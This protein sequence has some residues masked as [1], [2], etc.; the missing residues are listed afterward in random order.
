MIEV[1]RLPNES[2]E[3]LIYR[4]CSMKDSFGTWSEVRDILNKLLDKDYSE[5]KYRKW[6]KVYQAGLE[7]GLKKGQ[8]DS[9]YSDLDDKLNALKKERKKIQALNVERNKYDREETRRELFYEQIAENITSLPLVSFG[10]ISDEENVDHHDFEKEYVLCLADIH[11]GAKFKESYDEYSME[12]VQER[13]LCLL[14]EMSYF[15][16]DK[17]INHLHVLE[18][19]DTVQGLIHLS[20][21]KIIDSSMVRTIVEIS[22]LIAEFLN[23]LSSITKITY[24]HCGRANHTQIR[25]FNAKANEL[26]EEDVE[27]IIGHYIQDLL[28]NNDRVE[29]ILPDVNQSYIKLN[30]RANDIY[31]MHGHQLRNTDKAIDDVSNYL[32]ETVDYLIVGHEH[33]SKEI[34]TNAYSTFDK[35][36]LVCPSFVGSDP[37]SHSI[38]KRTHGAV[39]VFGF[40]EVYGHNETYKFI[41]D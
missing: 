41:L 32:A 28:R 16:K 3:S 14:D 13:F 15:I 34:T 33:C 25:A 22:R 20:D 38:L 17:G 5:S 4:V 9:D 1:K 23:Q 27:Y 2:D 29:V 8:S 39:K 36:V 19:G 31:A 40:N 21:L 10:Q 35:E 24:Y 7:E 26:A 37:Y 12:I 30:I 11:A 6:Y 18:L